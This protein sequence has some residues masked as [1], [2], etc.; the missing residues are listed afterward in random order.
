MTMRTKGTLTAEAG[1]IELD[2]ALEQD[3]QITS[4][5]FDKNPL[6]K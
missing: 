3:L 2:M 1:C 6:E 5:V 4:Q